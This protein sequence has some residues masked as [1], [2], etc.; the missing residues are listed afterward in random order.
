MQTCPAANAPSPSFLSVP[1]APSPVFD[2]PPTASSASG[3][4]R[5]SI[6][7]AAERQ[8]GVDAGEI[9]EAL[10]TVAWGLKHVG[11]AS[12]GIASISK[13]LISS[14][15]KTQKHSAWGSVISQV[16]H[17]REG[18]FLRVLFLINHPVLPVKRKTTCFHNM[19]I[20]GCKNIPMH[21][22]ETSW[23]FKAGTAKQKHPRQL[24]PHS[25]ISICVSQLLV[26][27]FALD[28]S[29]NGKTLPFPLPQ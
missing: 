20:Y 29:F 15:W 26:K 5:L 13:A 14:A 17:L 24:R 7:L 28:Q 22:T 8:D 4:V 6:L 12:G 11:K 3:P 25:T 9:R 18:Y 23:V 2:A 27:H 21:R 1:A 19:G 16:T 10:T